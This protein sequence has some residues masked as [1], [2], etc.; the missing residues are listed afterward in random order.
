MTWGSL[1]TRVLTH[2][3]VNRPWPGTSTS[4]KTPAWGAWS[5]R[6]AASRR[7]CGP[8]WDL[9]SSY[10]TGGTKMWET[11]GKPW[12]INHREMPVDLQKITNNETVFYFLSL[13]AMQNLTGAYWYDINLAGLFHMSLGW[14]CVGDFAGYQMNLRCLFCTSFVFERGE[15]YGIT[16]GK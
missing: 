13:W 9:S 14:R 6:H 15:G 5:C 12:V 7:C 8:C 10:G 1:G 11:C 3:H 2:P 4:G 16:L